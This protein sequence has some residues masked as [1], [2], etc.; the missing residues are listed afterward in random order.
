VGD[1]ADVLDP[2]ARIEHDVR[3]QQV[4]ADERRGA[5]HQGAI[6]PAHAGAAAH[7]PERNRHQQEEA[8]RL[9]LGGQRGR[10]EDAETEPRRQAGAARHPPPAPG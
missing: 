2:A 8:V 5:R 9:V 4:G 1:E 3:G 6:P 10:D 7:D